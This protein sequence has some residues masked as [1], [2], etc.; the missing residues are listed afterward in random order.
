MRKD[1]DPN[2]D[3]GSVDKGKC[4]DSRAHEEAGSLRSVG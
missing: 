3:N 4:I 2:W 1:I